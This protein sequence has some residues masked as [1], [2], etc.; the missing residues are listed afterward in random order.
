MKQF[1]RR[2]AL[3][4]GL[5]SCAALLSGCDWFS[6]TQEVTVS[7]GTASSPASAPPPS[8]ATAPTPAP[9][10]STSPSPTQ[11]TG[12]WDVNPWLIFPSG[13]NFVLDL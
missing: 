9:G 6:D 10:V 7:S 5:F 13:S 3:R 2:D 8:A 11:T 4:L 1:G 12:V